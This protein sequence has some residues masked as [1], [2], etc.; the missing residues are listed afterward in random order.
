MLLVRGRDEVPEK[1]REIGQPVLIPG[2]MGTSSYVLHGTQIAMEN[3]FWINCS[4]SWK[5][6]IK[7]QN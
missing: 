4:W 2:T 7:I 5:N 6:T 1:Y 3:T